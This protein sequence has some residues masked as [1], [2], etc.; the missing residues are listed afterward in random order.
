MRALALTSLLLVAC[1]PAGPIWEKSDTKVT[2]DLYA[3]DGVG[4]NDVWAV[5]ESGTAL[6]FDG[7][8]WTKVTSGTT[9]TLRSVWAASA[10]DVWM[11]GDS[12][13]VLRWNGTTLSAVSG[14]PDTQAFVSVRGL[15]SSVVFLCAQNGLFLFDG[16]FHEFTRG[17]NG[18]SHVRC[19]SLFELQGGVAALVEKDLS[20]SGE[21]QKLAANGGTVLDV[22]GTISSSF[23]SKMFAL[24]PSD[25]W[26]LNSSSSSVK[27]FGGDMP[28]ELTLPKDMGVSGGFARSA[29]DVWLCGS[30]GRL[31]QWDGMGSEATLKVAGGYEAPRMMAMWG[32]TDVLFAAGSGGWVLRLVE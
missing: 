14:A 3:L 11:V 20:S 24:G 25:F 32:Q 12:G 22:K 19:Q 18:T 9:R 17:G 16:T 2:D 8:S 6:H 23:E 29:T 30:Q 4:A 28:I 15:S 1:G 27:R 7:T 21:I 5:G 10:N 26:L 31:A 13:A